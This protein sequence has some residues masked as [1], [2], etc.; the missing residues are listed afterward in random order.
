MTAFPRAN[1]ISALTTLF[2]QH[3]AV[4][5]GATMAAYEQLAESSLDAVFAAGTT[6]EFV[7]LTDEER[8]D[9]CSAASDAFGADRTYWHVG[10]AST[11]QAVQLTQ[12]AVGRGAR[13][14][15][16]LT[17][18]Y[19]AATESALLSYYEAVVEQASGL[20]VY[21]YLF[22]ARST[23][24]VDPALLTRIADTGITGVKISGQPYTVV[25]EYVEALGDSNLPVYSGADSEFVEVV[26]VGGAGVVSGVSSALPKPFLEVRDALRAGN[27]SALSAARERAHRAVTATRQG[28]LASLKA[29]LE[30][31][32]LDAS[33]M[34]APMDP[35]SPADRTQLASDVSDLL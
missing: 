21:G 26:E 2:D 24:S 1:L 27:E 32:G 5:L 12:A 17:P 25:R 29:V 6:G 19:F 8:L 35:I 22:P 15:A 23:T 18:Y 10:S 9:V 4:D 11:H 20:P 7:T 16:A 13:H 3:G 30:L 31:R 33:S 28:H 34:R 14:L